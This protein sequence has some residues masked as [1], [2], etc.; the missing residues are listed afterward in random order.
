[1]NTASL[2]PLFLVVF[3]LTA[4]ASAQERKI[5]FG[6]TARSMSSLPLLFAQSNGFYRTEGLYAEFI[7]ISPTLAIQAQIAGELEFS[8]ITS[9]AARAAIAGMPIRLVIGCGA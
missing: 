9:V 7:Q 2:A 5:R 6:M 4:A 1:V 3:L 8:T